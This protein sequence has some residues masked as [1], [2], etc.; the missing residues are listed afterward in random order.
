M[1]HRQGILRYHKYNLDI[2]MYNNKFVMEKLS[3]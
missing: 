3:V 2:N 1:T